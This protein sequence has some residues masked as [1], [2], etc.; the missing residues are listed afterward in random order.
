M[1]EFRCWE[2]CALIKALRRA[3]DPCREMAVL[4]RY[5]AAAECAGEQPMES[6]V[7]RLNAACLANRIASTQC[8]KATN[9]Q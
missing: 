4:E 2:Q 8:V 1:G 7:K 9:D 6:L 5:A 3:K